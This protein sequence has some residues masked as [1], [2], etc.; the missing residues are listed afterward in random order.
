MWK[1]GTSEGRSP[2]PST[3][4]S[5]SHVSFAGGLWHWGKT[6]HMV[7]RR[8][9]VSAMVQALG[10]LLS[11]EQQNPPSCSFGK[12]TDYILKQSLKYVAHGPVVNPKQDKAGKMWESGQNCRS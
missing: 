5:L 12:V 8:M 11:P 4:P 6:I 10:S 3:S 7:V 1:S 2:L 9:G